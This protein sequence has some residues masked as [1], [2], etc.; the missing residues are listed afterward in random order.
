M[1][2]NKAAVLLLLVSAWWMAPAYADE[3]RLGLVTMGP[4]E[5]Y[6]QRFGHNAI[7]IENLDS[8][9]QS[10][11]NYGFFDFRQEDFFLNF[12]RGEMQYFMAATDPQRDMAQYA[13]TG[14]SLHI[15]WLNLSQGQ[16]TSL[17]EFLRW[18]ARPENRDYRY[19]YF[20]S[21]CSTKVRDVLDR[22]LGGALQRAWSR[23]PSDYSYRQEAYRMTQ[24]D[25]W[26]HLGIRLGLGRLTDQP[27]SVWQE[28]FLP[29]RLLEKMQQEPELQ[30]LLGAEQTVYQGQ[31][32][33]EQAADWWWGFALVGIG[34][35]LLILLAWG[36]LSTLVM[37]LWWLLSG[38]VGIGVLALWLATA[39]WAAW[40][41]ENLM[42][43]S[44]W[45]LLA[46]LVLKRKNG[47]SRSLGK[48]IVVAAPVQTLLMVV[49]QSF[50]DFMWQQNL[51][52]VLLVF[53]IQIAILVQTWRRSRRQRSNAE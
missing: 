44:P 22:T 27:M 31:V 37:S 18:N 23:L 8:G 1:L 11:Y 36:W 4:G 38:F 5:I 28:G 39:H 41:N 12:I 16:I 29:H 17:H 49:L 10:L 6:W 48:V 47:F 24:G 20:L 21:N 14:R 40:Q 52:W 32:V 26:L 45:A 7:L 34:I 33:P 9:E 3:W 53:P 15:Q 19:D 46:F 43:F 51:E 35:A 13:R 30:P 2:R 50:T 25:L 42:L